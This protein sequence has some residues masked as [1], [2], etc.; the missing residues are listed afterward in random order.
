MSQKT[1]RSQNVS[2]STVVI[3][4]GLGFAFKFK[5]FWDY[6]ELLYFFIWKDIKVRYKQTM[7][8]AAWVVIQPFFTMVVFSIIFGKFA[9]IPTGG[10]PYPIFVYS[11]LVP[12]TYFA[13]SLTKTTN[14][15]VINQ[16]VITKV[17]FPRLILPVSAV[18]SGIP[19]FLISFSVLI[20]MMFFYG[21]IPTANLFLL[22]LFM[23]LVIVTALAVGLWTSA[24][25]AIYRD[26]QYVVPFIIQLWLFA[27]P[28]VYSSS[29]LPQNWRIIYGLNPMVG[30]IEGFRWALLGK[31]EPLGP[32][33]VVSVLIIFC[34]LISGIIYFRRMEG[35]IADI[36]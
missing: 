18:M 13:N 12:W 7:I 14:T 17:Y 26:V 2:Y 31:E 19:D 8:G 3:K 1:M 33:F 11:A 21:I 5:E 36:I 30:I 25:N 22:P 9:K 24:A 10:I 20:G 23:L 29:L 28:V 27:S 15:M 35:T 4:P 6:R 32:M 34:I 16:N